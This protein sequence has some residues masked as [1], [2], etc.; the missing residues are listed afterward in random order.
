M[1][2]A[3]IVHFTHFFTFTTV[4]SLTIYCTT[5]FIYLYLAIQTNTQLIYLMAIQS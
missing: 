2:T 4:K 3:R 5:V 1:Y